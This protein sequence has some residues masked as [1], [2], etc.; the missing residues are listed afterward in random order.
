MGK[1]ELSKHK[2]ACLCLLWKRKE[3]SHQFPKNK[4]DWNKMDANN[5]KTVKTYDGLHYY[6]LFITFKQMKSLRYGWRCFQWYLILVS[7]F[8]LRF[9]LR[10][11]FDWEDISNTQDTV[12]P[13]FQTPWGTSKISVVFSIS[14][15]VVWICGQNQSFVFDILLKTSLQICKRSRLV[16]PMLQLC[17]YVFSKIA[18]E[19][20][21]GE[22]GKKNRPARNRRTSEAIGRDSAEIPSFFRS[23]Y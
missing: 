3:Y 18:C 12:W 11:S 15:L 8:F 2:A 14:L 21:S 20:A 5:R 13:H 10:L 4:V 9:L 23:R 22:D 7:K 1:L 17:T 19:Q 16:S 6:Q